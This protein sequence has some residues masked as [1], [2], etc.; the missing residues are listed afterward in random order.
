M[1][2][3]AIEVSTTDQAWAEKHATPAAEGRYTVPGCSI[4]RR[5]QFCGRDWVNYTLPAGVP[6]PAGWNVAKSAAQSGVLAAPA[7]WVHETV[8]A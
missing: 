6:I 5:Y 7:I 8:S 1:T 4:T 3:A 2:T